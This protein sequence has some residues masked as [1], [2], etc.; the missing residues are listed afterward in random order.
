MHKTIFLAV[1][2]LMAGMMSVP[3]LAEGSASTLPGGASSLQETYQ[4]WQVSCVQQQADKR[5]ALSQQQRQRNGQNVLSIELTTI[6]EAAEA[7]GILV[8]PFGLLL[9]NGATLQIDDAT[10]GSALPFSTCLPA[11]CL[12]PLAFDGNML[13]AMRK[14]TALNISAAASGTNQ[15]VRLRV[16][17]AGFSAALDRT[18]ALLK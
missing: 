9:S 8:L 10:P 4:D 6:A 18:A 13:A 16:S 2:T 1:S 7:D 15:P 12:V 17:L 11:G 3:A 5:C 14:G